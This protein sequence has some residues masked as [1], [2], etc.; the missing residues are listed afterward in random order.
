[1]NNLELPSRETVAAH[2]VAKDEKPKIRVW[3]V[4]GHRDLG[5]NCSCHVTSMAFGSDEDRA[6]KNFDRMQNKPAFSST[7]QRQLWRRHELTF[8]EIQQ[9]GV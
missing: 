6:W 8:E 4:E 5:A 1:M 2:T 3:R 9:E 7:G